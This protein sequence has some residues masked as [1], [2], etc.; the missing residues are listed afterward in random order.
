MPRDPN[1]THSLAPKAPSPHC[2]VRDVTGVGVSWGR[3]KKA[4][5]ALNTPILDAGVGGET[6]AIKYA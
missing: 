2:A 1:T 5:A 3:K 4:G 6:R